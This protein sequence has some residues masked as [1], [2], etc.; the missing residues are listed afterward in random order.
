MKKNES[1]SFP[2]GVAAIGTALVIGTLGLLTSLT[3]ISPGYAGIMY[4]KNGGI[5]DEVL[6]QGWHLVS[7]MTSVIS[8]PVSTETA[9]F[10]HSEGEGRKSDDT[11]LIG[12]KDGKTVKVDAQLFY[13]MDRDF[14]GKIFTKF[15]GADAEAIAYGY[16]RQNTQ[17]IMNDI[18]SKYSIVDLAGESKPQ[19]NAE[20]F[21]A[22]S[23]FFGKDGIIIEEAGL[24]RVEPDEATKAR[25]QA[26]TD[27]QYREKQAEYEKEVAKAQA[28]KLLVEVEA[29]AQA[30]KIEADATAYYNQKVTESAS[31]DVV[32]LKWIEKWDG[33]LPTYSLGES[34]PLINIK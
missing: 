31:Q 25:I 7:P 15:R 11:L 16:M 33:K 14:L 10:N 12:T 24:G 17:R 2:L 23:D 9:Y 28:E 19:F 1:S 32:Q 18:S 30:K 4:N 6:G 29:K 26:V 8:Y 27:A 3:T 20:V 5:E 13:H 34:S 22:L 21:T